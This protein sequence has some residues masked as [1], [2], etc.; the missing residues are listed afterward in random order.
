MGLFIYKY[1]ADTSF[2]MIS[3]VD[4]GGF[5]SDP[6][7]LVQVLSIC[8]QVFQYD[9]AKKCT[10]GDYMPFYVI[11]MLLVVFFVF[12]APFAI[13]YI[14]ARRPRVSLIIVLLV[15]C[16]RGVMSGFVSLSHY[17]NIALLSYM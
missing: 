13:G 10:D 17:A 1:I 2:V 16:C 7:S 4:A 6:L 8:V 11:G 5:V 12:P 9:G 3:C 14:C 15:L